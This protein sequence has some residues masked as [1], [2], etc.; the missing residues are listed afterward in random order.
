MGQGKCSTIEIAGYCNLNIF[1]GEWNLKVCYL[2]SN[3]RRENFKRNWE[4]EIFR[5]GLGWGKE[6]LMEERGKL[7]QD[8]RGSSWGETRLWNKHFWK[9]SK[10]EMN[11]SCY[12]KE[13]LHE[14]WVWWGLKNIPALCL[15]VLVEL[16]DHCVFHLPLAA[17]SSRWALPEQKNQ[18]GKWDLPQKKIDQEQI[19]IYTFSFFFSTP[20]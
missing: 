18:L 11:K 17:L 6:H 2:A 16:E 7:V 15:K 13:N 20:R 5:K 9:R 1:V 8:E 10:L 3:S 19:Y 12:G 4:K 14:S